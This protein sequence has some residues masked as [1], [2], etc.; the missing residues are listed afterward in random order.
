[1]P[2]PTHGGVAGGPGPRTPPGGQVT[3]A[4]QADG[5]GGTLLRDA[6]PSAAGTGAGGRAGPVGGRPAHDVARPVGLEQVPL[7]GGDRIR[8]SMAN[9]RSSDPG[10]V[11]VAAGPDA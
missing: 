7:L 9:A 10:D 3:G 1:M 2:A 11:V 8:S 4:D 6:E 5:I